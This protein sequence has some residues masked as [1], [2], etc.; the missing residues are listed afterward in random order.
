MQKVTR[1]SFRQMRNPALESLWSVVLN[2]NWLR[3]G[4]ICPCLSSWKSFFFPFKLFPLI[5]VFKW[6]VKWNFMIAGRIVRLFINVCYCFTVLC[7]V[8]C[9][10]PHSPI[11]F[12]HGA[13]V[14]WTWDIC[15]IHPS[16]QN[17]PWPEHTVRAHSVVWHTSSAYVYLENV[18]IF[19][20]TE[21]RKQK[22][23]IGLLGHPPSI[24]VNPQQPA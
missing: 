1:N 18:S 5:L 12:R 10:M 19:Q 9:A 7:T 16:R 23:R 2:L 21:Q 13:D 4:I 20:M 3:I 8:C 11:L 17:K 15:S 6:A 24:N 22:Q 14:A